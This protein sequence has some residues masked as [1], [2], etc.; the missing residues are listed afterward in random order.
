MTNIQN[1]WSGINIQLQELIERKRAEVKGEK[2][3]YETN[4]YEKQLMIML[5]EN[6]TEQ[7]AK[8]KVK[9]EAFEQND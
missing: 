7:L 6:L 5:Q 4:E 9:F 3:I 8:E 1:P 2:I